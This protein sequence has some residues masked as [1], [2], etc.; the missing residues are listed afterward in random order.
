[1]LHGGL[2]KRKMASECKPLWLLGYPED[3]QIDPMKTFI[4]RLRQK[5]GRLPTRQEPRRMGWA[6]RTVLPFLFTLA[7]FV[8]LPGRPAASQ[9]SVFEL[10]REAGRG[11]LSVSQVRTILEPI[12]VADHV[13]LRLAL[14]NEDPYCRMAAAE[15]LGSLGEAPTEEMVGLLKDEDLGVRDSA[16]AALMVIGVPSVQPV[17]GFLNSEAAGSDAADRALRILHAV[18]TPDVIPFLSAYLVRNRRGGFRQQETLEAMMRLGE[19]GFRPLIGLMQYTDLRE[20]VFLILFEY[21]PKE[22]AR[23]LAGQCGR[24]AR[25]PQETLLAAQL[26]EEILGTAY[27]ERELNACYLEIAS[28]SGIPMPIR[29]QADN[30]RWKMMADPLQPLTR[31]MVEARFDD[32]YREE[33][34]LLHIEQIMKER[35]LQ[36]R[37]RIREEE[38]KKAL[39]EARRDES[40]KKYLKEREEDRRAGRERDEE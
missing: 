18:G 8:V 13:A 28:D 6:G 27:A 14:T 12:E 37:E 25:E 39:Q 35:A 22:L 32:L 19:L 5:P 21:P 11:S 36:M 2:W 10:L 3:W 16:E 40:L 15:L 38:Q 4:R 29:L 9:E 34:R 20:S 33:R 1:M 23:G 30:S 31:E 26:V 24:A 7:S 17:G